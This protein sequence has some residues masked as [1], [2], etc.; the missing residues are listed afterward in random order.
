MPWFKD[1]TSLAHVIY[2]IYMETVK[3][4]LQPQISDLFDDGRKKKR[5]ELLKKLHIVLKQVHVL[6]QESRDDQPL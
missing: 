6:E 5:A 1:P 4:F 2:S 3:I